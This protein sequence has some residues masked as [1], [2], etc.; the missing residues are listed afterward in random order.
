MT[1]CQSSQSNEFIGT[2][3]CC[4]KRGRK[5][6]LRREGLPMCKSC[7]L[8]NRLNKIEK[9]MYLKQFFNT[10]DI[11]CEQS[12][13]EA[14]ETGNAKRQVQGGVYWRMLPLLW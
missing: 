2:C 3:F 8:L 4:N 14:V 5:I 11:F 12:I 9:I 1:D 10:W 13:H 7:V 6:G